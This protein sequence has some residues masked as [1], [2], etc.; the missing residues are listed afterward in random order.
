MPHRYLLRSSLPNIPEN[1]IVSHSTVNI[2]MA[3]KEDIA[4]LLKKHNKT[5][6]SFEPYDF[7]GKTTEN[8]KDFMTSFNNYSKLNNIDEAEKI[9]TFEMC[10]KGTAKC[11]FSTLPEETRNKFD[12][13]QEHFIK[14]YS[15]NNKWLNTARLENRKL[16]TTESAEK[17]IADMSN[18]AMLVGVEDDEL[19]KALIRGLPS[20]LRWHVISFNPTTLNETI[21]RILLGEATLASDY[22]DQLNAIE[23]NTMIAVVRK[24]DERLDKI[25]NAIKYN[26]NSQVQRNTNQYSNTGSTTPTCQICNKFGHGATD[27]FRNNTQRFDN[28]SSRAYNYTPARGGGNFRSPAPGRGNMFYNNRTNNQYRGGYNSTYG[29]GVGR[30]FDRNQNGNYM[31]KK[32]D[33][34]P[35]V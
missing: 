13:I 11:W 35:R 15:Q 20:K 33:A 23:D 17:Y 4:D 2:K 12:K 1:S 34:T 24:L 25:E 5:R 16:L 32:N 31:F 28:R 19:M 30:G 18:L 9:L 21:Q 8:A 29:S 10:L 6:K 7:S 27:C 26:S 14:N 22:G 3:S